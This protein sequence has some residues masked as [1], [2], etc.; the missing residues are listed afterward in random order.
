MSR[1]ATVPLP[2]GAPVGL[3][4]TRDHHGVPHLTAPELGSLLWG[5]GYCHALDRGLQ[6]LLTR[7]VG[8]GRASECL[9]ANAET[10]EIDRFFRRLGGRESAIS[11]SEQLTE[12]DAGLTAAYV[13][14]INARLRQ[15]LP[16]ELR[17]VGYQ[18]EP[19]TAADSVLLSR[20]VGY[21]GLAQTQG[22]LERLFVEMVQAGVDDRCLRALFPNIGELAALDGSDVRL[23][24]RALLQRVRLG[25]RLVPEA[26]RW[27]SAVPSAAASNA[28]AVAPHKTRSGRALLA[29]DP[30]LQVNRLPN[31]WYEIVARFG[32]EPRHYTLAA[33]MPGLPAPLLGR[34]AGLAW[35]ATYSFLDGI[36]SWIEDCR[37]GAYR[38]GDRFVPFRVRHER[39]LRKKQPPLDLTFYENEHGVLDGDPHQP[40]Y[41]L[42]TRWAG[43][44]SGARSLAA[45]LRMWTARDV[46]EGRAQLGQVETGWV[47][48]LAD[49][50]GNIALQMSG[51]VPRRRA[52]VSGFL[53]LPGWF[54]DND[55]HGFLSSTE[56]PQRK[57]PPEGFV[58][59]ANH[60]L[61]AYGRVPVQNAT[62][63]DYRADRIRQL[64]EP[65]NDLTVEDCRAIQYDVV[66]LQAQQFLQRLRPLLPDDANGRLLREWDGSYTR[67]STAATLFERFYRELGSLVLGRYLLGPDV[68]A[69]LRSNTA[70][71][72]AH[73]KNFETVLL[74]PPCEL[75]GDRSRDDLYREAYAAA[76]SAGPPEPLQTQSQLRLEQLFFGGRLPRWL[77]FDRGPVS[78]A[79]SRA[80][81]CQTQFYRAVGHDGCLAASIRIA[82]DLAEDTLHTNLCGGPSDRRFSPWY[83]SDLDA[84]VEGRYKVLQP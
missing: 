69:H 4:L 19:W 39:V 52:G 76:V 18:P 61:G 32:I 25:E 83:C 53:P 54:E 64:L 46:D 14:G 12:Q 49:R 3:Y 22:E 79:G 34:S 73:F 37:D 9:T 74:D 8:Q 6:L 43:S 26:V 29:N 41:L 11:Q 62:A 71:I 60:D 67:E 82:T 23:P 78:L 30:H 2:S 70:L 57:N 38:R 40:G 51:L 65:R 44:H 21:V 72:T 81:V 36:D 5:L 42:S 77:G 20:V 24:S 10:L 47:W 33:T 28:W 59:A 27:L 68:L 50:A 15:E 35:G 63:P 56:L 31:V 45:M 55:W 17:L 66:S 16:W 1:T 75:C 48:S 84:W 7:I 80:T 58:I 13:A